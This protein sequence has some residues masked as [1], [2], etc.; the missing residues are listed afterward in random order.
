M[1]EENSWTN[2][3]AI[4]VQWQRRD[5]PPDDE[6]DPS[7]ILLLSDMLS[8]LL[9]FSKILS[10]TFSALQVLPLF[11]PDVRVIL[12]LLA[13]EAEPLSRHVFWLVEPHNA[14]HQSQKCLHLRQY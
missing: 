12:S 8:L 6:P 1:E 2:F 4:V 3:F 11:G 9:V 14:H 13:L 5:P 10:P 7:G